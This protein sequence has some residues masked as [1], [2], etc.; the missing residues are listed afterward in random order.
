M[1]MGWISIAFVL[2][3]FVKSLHY[4]ASLKVLFSRFLKYSNKS[5][6]SLLMSQLSLKEQLT[7][8]SVGP[9]DISSSM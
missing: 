7:V 3:E 4:V 1:T 8:L 2:N 5:L 9:G 6:F